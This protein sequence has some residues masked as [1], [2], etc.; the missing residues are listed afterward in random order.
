[1]KKSRYYIII[2]F[3]FALSMSALFFYIGTQKTGFLTSS[4]NQDSSLKIVFD[5]LPPTGK[6]LFYKQSN[7][8][9]TPVDAKLVALDNETITCGGIISSQFSVGSNPGGSCVGPGTVITENSPNLGGQCCGALTDVGKYYTQLEESKKY[10]YIPDVPSDPYNV[11]IE[12]AKKWI[13]FDYSTNLNPEQQKVLNSAA[14][15]SDEGGP[16]CCRCWHW[17]LN[18]GIA[19]NMIINYNFTSRQVADF[20]D[21]ADI[22]GN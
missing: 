8:L 17:Y 7:G 12:I 18:E 9:N 22:C 11:S 14:S 20:Y 3:V 19:K 13:A 10:A 16:C 4:T 6:S 15:L 1:M 2:L 5:S 21:S